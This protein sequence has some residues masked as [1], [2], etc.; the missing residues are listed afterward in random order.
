MYLKIKRFFY[1]IRSIG[2]SV[3]VFVMP[4]GVLVSQ[5]DCLGKI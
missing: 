1:K 2:I 4:F 3:G 5:W